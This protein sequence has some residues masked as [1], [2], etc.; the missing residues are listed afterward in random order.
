[1]ALKLGTGERLEESEEHDW[2]KT[3]IPW[4]VNRNIE[5]RDVSV[6]AQKEP[7]NILLETSNR[8]ITIVW[9]QKASGRFLQQ[10]GGKHSWVMDFT[11]DELKMISRVCILSIYSQSIQYNLCTINML[12][13]IS[14]SSLDFSLELQTH[15]SHRLKSDRPKMYSCFTSKPPLE[16]RD[17]CWQHR[18]EKKAECA[19][20][21]P[22]VITSERQK[23]QSIQSHKRP[24]QEIKGVS[25]R[26]SH[27]RGPSGSL[28]TVFSRPPQQ[29]A[30]E[31]RNYLKNTCGGG[32]CGMEWIPINRNSSLGSWENFTRNTDFW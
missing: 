19:N 12:I 25:H 8:R 21:K 30:K 32:V 20:I 27:T 24:F 18:T 15:T 26:A 23:N 2:R 22:F 4:I 16:L 3:R 17:C 1:M 10:L 29:E 14:I 13:P 11:C 6:R 9:W 31:R 28:R 7:V 5:L